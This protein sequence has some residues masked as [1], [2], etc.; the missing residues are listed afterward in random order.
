MK[1]LHADFFILCASDKISQLIPTELGSWNMPEIICV[2]K[3]IHA[4]NQAER[5]DHYLQKPHDFVFPSPGELKVN[6]QQTVVD[7]KGDYTECLT[8]VDRVSLE[9][10]FPDINQIKEQ[11]N[12]FYK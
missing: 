9:R 1:A 5:K 4:K 2:V 12:N 10:K 8:H 7:L 6:L 3:R 11:E